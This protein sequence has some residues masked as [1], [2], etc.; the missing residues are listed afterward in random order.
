MKIF[1][2]QLKQDAA[3]TV[4]KSQLNIHKMRI[5]HKWTKI[6]QVRWRNVFKCDKCN[7]YRLELY[8][9]VYSYSRTNF[10]DNSENAITI[11]C[12]SCDFTDCKHKFLLNEQKN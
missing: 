11:D 4:A 8:A 1:I 2:L 6:G 3:D 12:P 10:I 9:G 5:K 7:L